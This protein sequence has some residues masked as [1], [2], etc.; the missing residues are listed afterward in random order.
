M[1]TIQL[2]YMGKPK[3]TVVDATRTTVNKRIIPFSDLSRYE[4]EQV[5]QTLATP[6]PYEMWNRKVRHISELLDIDERDAERLMFQRIG[7]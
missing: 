3:E 1:K 7:Q 2:P 4:M 6:G 5:E